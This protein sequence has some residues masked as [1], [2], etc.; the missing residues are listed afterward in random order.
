MDR[1]AAPALL[2]ARLSLRLQVLVQ[3]LE[4]Y[5]VCVW[6][7]SPRPPPALP[8]GRSS[9]SPAPPPLPR[10]PR[11]AAPRPHTPP[12]LRGGQSCASR[13]FAVAAEEVGLGG[14]RAQ[15]EL[16]GIGETFDI[17]I[18]MFPSARPPSPPPFRGSGW[19]DEV[20]ERRSEGAGRRPGSQGDGGTSPRR[21]CFVLGWLVGLG[22]KRPR[23]RRG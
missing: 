18:P 8:G 5:Q 10:R 9:G 21:F 17:S 20:T 23:G 4:Q 19:R 12:A 7:L 15:Q 22:R 6:R 2:T 3:E 16:R 13:V 11:P 14:Q 1:G